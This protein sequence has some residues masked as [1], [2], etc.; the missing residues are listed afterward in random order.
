MSRQLSSLLD[1]DAKAEAF[2]AML[3]ARGDGML[4][5]AVEVVGAEIR[6]GGTVLEDVVGD[7]E[8]RVSDGHG[9]ALG[10]TTCS[11]TVVLSSEV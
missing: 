6:V 4:G 8:D 10:A 11:E 1:G 2:E 3:G 5:S 9:S 7:D